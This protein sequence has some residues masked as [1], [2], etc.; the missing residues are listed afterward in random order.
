MIRGEYWKEGR[1]GEGKWEESYVFGRILLSSHTISRSLNNLTSL[2]A[3]TLICIFPRFSDLI[4]INC[5]KY[6]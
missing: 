1:K 3:L 5:P 2:Y 6:S 4:R